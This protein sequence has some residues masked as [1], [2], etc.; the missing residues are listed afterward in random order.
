M[1]IHLSQWTLL[2]ALQIVHWIYAHFLIF[3][4]F[5]LVFLPYS[6]AIFSNP[7]MVYCAL[8]T[9]CWCIYRA[10][11][12]MELLCLIW[13]KAGNLFKI[14]DLTDFTVIVQFFR[15]VSSKTIWSFR[16]YCSFQ[17][18][19][20]SFEW[21]NV[22]LNLWIYSTYLKILNTTSSDGNC[23]KLKQFYAIQCASVANNLVTS[24]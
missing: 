23:D 13:E 6:N 14:I 5:C 21:K 12:L 18:L 8:N 11:G 20:L 19:S 10:L 16:H 4:F 22:L 7:Y 15:W 1:D 2:H 9:Y 17:D 24:E 3:V